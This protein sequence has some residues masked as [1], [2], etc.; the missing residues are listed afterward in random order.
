MMNNKT[1]MTMS[2]KLNAKELAA[3]RYPLPDDEPS[4]DEHQKQ[5]AYAA[6]IRE[7]A[8]PIADE[9]AALR[10]Q[11]L[12]LYDLKLIAQVSGPSLGWT[13]RGGKLYRDYHGRKDRVFWQDGRLHVQWWSHCDADPIAQARSF[14][15]GSGRVL[16]PVL[17]RNDSDYASVREWLEEVYGPPSA[18]TL[19]WDGVAER[20]RGFELEAYRSTSMGGD[21]WTYFSVFRIRDGREMS[22]GYDGI[23]DVREF[24][25][26]L[27]KR[28]DAFL[29]MPL[30]ERRDPDKF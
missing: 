17:K 12:T 8:Q 30:A 13:L 2:T 24:M 28:V 18:F 5:L 26:Y 23:E 25:Q 16:P 4:W 20:Y 3:K 27:K 14:S 6:A 21:E 29:K 1:G 15:H 19:P 22:S 10:P 11:A 9:R 7:V